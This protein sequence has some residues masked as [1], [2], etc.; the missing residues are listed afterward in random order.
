[1]PVGDELAWRVVWS[2]DK[3]RT[4]H[5]EA[6]AEFTDF[7]RLAEIGLKGVHIDPEA[8]AEAEEREKAAAKEFSNILKMAGMLEIKEH[9]PNPTPE[10]RPPL[11]E[12]QPE[13]AG[14]LHSAYIF[15][16]PTREHALGIMA[17]AFWAVARA[18][19]DDLDKAFVD[20]AFKQIVR[21]VDTRYLDRGADEPMMT[22]DTLE[23]LIDHANQ[24]EGSTQKFGPATLGVFNLVSQFVVTNKE[25]LLR[26]LPQNADEQ[27]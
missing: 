10:V 22:L 14:E 23:E 26:G 9:D 8:Y 1:M 27:A 12:E 19:Q 17:W 25:V 13:L 2:A 16:H 7:K 18:L 21:K 4:Q 24:P 5:Q 11:E 15:R 3:A 20:R 6:S